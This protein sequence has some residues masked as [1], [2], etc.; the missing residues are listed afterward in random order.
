MTSS[1]TGIFFH[2]QQGDRLRDFPAALD[3]ILDKGNVIYYDALYDSPPDT[4]YDILPIPESDLRCVHTREMLERVRRTG[5]FEGAHYSAAGTV[6]A[7]VK[8]ISGELTNAFVF[9]GYGDHHAGSS[10]FGGGC[11]LNGIAVAAHVIKERFNVKRIAVVDTD[12]H[13]GDGSWEIFETNPDALYICFCSGRSFENK[14]NVNINVPYS[15]GDEGYLALAGDAF[16]RWIKPHQPEI[17]FWNWGY[18]GTSGDY[19]DMGLTHGFHFKMAGRLKRLAEEVCEGRMA[20]V[21]CGGS[22]RDLAREL[23]PGVIRALAGLEI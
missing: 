1:S 21:L 12:A 17:V 18:D 13:H 11:Y 14:G 9:T 6:A 20:T 2:Y 7:A 5:E 16:N 23:I 4:M 15:A 22:R 19:G 3:G 10:F 8:I